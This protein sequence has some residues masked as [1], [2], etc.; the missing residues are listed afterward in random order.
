MISAVGAVLGIIG[1][2]IL[3]FIQ[4]YYGVIKLGQ[5]YL[6]DAYPVI[7]NVSDSL[8]VLLTVLVMGLLAAYYPVRYIS[9]KSMG[10]ND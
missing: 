3:C 2:N 4:E 5:E 6:V 10:I 7:T 1:G 8:L 9:A